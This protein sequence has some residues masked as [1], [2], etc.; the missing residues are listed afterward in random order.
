MSGVSLTASAGPRVI[1]GLIGPTDK[2]NLRDFKLLGLDVKYQDCQIEANE[3]PNIHAFT[4][5]HL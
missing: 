4:R 2:S 1:A 3:V 5:K